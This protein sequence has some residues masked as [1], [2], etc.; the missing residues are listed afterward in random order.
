MAYT[1]LEEQE[2]NEIKNF[3]KENGKTII[4][5]VIIA[6]AG[7][8]GWRYWQSYQLSQHHQLS[9]QY[10][11]VIYEFRQDPA[12]Q[13]DNLAEFITQNGKSGYAALALFE[14]A[15]TAVEKQDFSQAETA[16]KQ[17]LNSAPDEIFASIAA[18]R[19]ANVQFQQKD[20]DG[21]LVS[22]NL[23]KDTSWDSRKQILNGDILLAKGDKAG[24]KAAY[25]QAQKNASALEQQWLQVR[26]NNL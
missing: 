19:L 7:V 26:L 23:V 20:F 6:I 5:S 8:F 9:D 1:S 25:Q 17:A 15:K 24:A 21:A 16:L 4:V 18:L 10:Q 13:K 2:I 14:Q 3:W 22:L 12:A 11:Q